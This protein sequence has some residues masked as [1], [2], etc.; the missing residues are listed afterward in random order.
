MPAHLPNRSLSLISIAVIH[1]AILN[2]LYQVPNRLHDSGGR[3]ADRVGG[4]AVDWYPTLGCPTS[5]R[6]SK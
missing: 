5:N 1:E 3:L 2:G 4:Q 6:A